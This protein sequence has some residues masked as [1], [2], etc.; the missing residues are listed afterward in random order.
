VLNQ[1]FQKKATEILKKTDIT[2][3]GNK[4]WDIQIYDTDIARDVFLKGSLGF[5]DGYINKKWDA[6][7]LDLFFEK[8]LAIK[9]SLSPNLIDIIFNMRN[10]LINTQIG[11]RAFHVGEHHYDL[12]NKMYEYMLGESMGYSCGMFLNKSDDLTKAQ[13]NK[14]D[15]LCKKLNLKPGMRV[16]EVGSGWGTFARH[17]A[18]NYGVSVVGLT[19]SKEQLTFARE[20]CKGL[21]VK[22]L[23]LDYQNLG[24]NYNR[25]FDRVVSIE[26]IEAV[27]RKN[28]ATYFEVIA[29]V[30]KDNGLFG[31]Q[32]ILGSG[33][34]DT[35]I[36]TRI[37]PNGVAPSTK[38]I[39]LYSEKVLNIQ[40]WINFGKDYDKTLMAWE[41]NFRLN[42]KNIKNIKDNK[43]NAIYDEKFYRMWRYYLLICAVLFRLGKT[44]DAQIIMSKK[45]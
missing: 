27:G 18:K 20:R 45:I 7:K 25:Y 42:W 10:F 16:L 13:Y 2:I 44:D 31:L 22:F 11:K 26:M 40:S 5:G 9:P 19:V 4:P 38:D 30:L 3:N 8:L 24:Q 6:E 15:A 37:F 14:F 29:R 43:G 34:T 12:G 41:S 1:F 21:P 28:F 17:A 32:S 23:L 36:S 33:K 35:F 39:V